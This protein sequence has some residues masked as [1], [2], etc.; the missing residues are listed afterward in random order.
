MFHVY[1]ITFAF[2]WL[3][4]SIRIHSVALAWRIF[5]NLENNVELKRKYILFQQT[6]LVCFTRITCFHSRKRKQQT[7]SYI[8]VASR[9]EPLPILLSIVL[10]LRT[11]KF[12]LLVRMRSLLCA[13]SLRLIDDDSMI[14]VVSG[15]LI[16]YLLSEIRLVRQKTEY[17]CLTDC[18]R[19]LRL[20]VH[21][22]KY[23]SFNTKCLMDGSHNFIAH[24]RFKVN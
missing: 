14:T 24:L 1:R 17:T 10:C 4:D 11:L 18:F 3:F 22:S 15:F 21:Y 2:V 12:F 8:V 16:V 7:F 9:F 6:T 23:S 5:I 20:D 19:S 13:S